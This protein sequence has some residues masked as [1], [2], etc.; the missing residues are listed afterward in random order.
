[1]Q[2]F[3]LARHADGKRAILLADPAFPGYRASTDPAG[4]IARLREALVAACNAVGVHV[5]P[6][7]HHIFR[8]TDGGPEA[9]ANVHVTRGLVPPRPLAEL[10]ALREEPEGSWARDAAAAGGQGWEVPLFDAAGRGSA[11][12]LTAQLAPLQ[13]NDHLHAA[14][15]HLDDNN[16]TASAVAKANTE[17]TLRVKPGEVP[18]LGTVR[19]Q[20]IE[21]FLLQLQKKK[22]PTICPQCG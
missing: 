14:C 13:C 1:M 20:A 10:A 3:G 22:I 6:Y 8:S 5:P 18:Y 19:I 17:I 21:P 9:I 4:P 16:I 15:L 2:D 12:H 7:R 11:I